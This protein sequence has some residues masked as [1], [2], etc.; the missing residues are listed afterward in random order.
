M[1]DMLIASSAVKE[2]KEGAKQ[3]DLA[4]HYFL[5]G[6]KFN[7]SEGMLRNLLGMV[8]RHLS[9]PLLNWEGQWLFRHIS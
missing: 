3:Y 6:R 5:K 4:Y 1:D 2:S 7:T 8:N 9:A